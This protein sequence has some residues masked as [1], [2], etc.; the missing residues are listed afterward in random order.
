MSRSVER[1]CEW[2]YRGLWGVLTR[3]FKVPQHPPELPARADEHV[4]A[5]RPSLGFLRYLKLKFWIGLFVVD[6]AI[7]VGWVVVLLVSR[8][9]GLILAPVALVVAVVPDIIAYVAIHLRYDTTWYVMSQRSLR[10]RRGIWVIHETTITFENVQNVAVR[11]GPIQRLFGIANILV[12]TAG[13]GAEAQHGAH[14]ARHAVA[15]RGL[16]EGISEP[17]RL[18]DLILRRLRG[19]RSTGLGDEGPAEM[20]AHR[21][22]CREH[23]AVLTDIRDALGELVR[24]QAAAQ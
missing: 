11:Q 13:G 14:G 5:F 9:A 21:G 7:L 17:Q 6:L 2:I 15:H 18:R 12:D 10:I 19:T 20:A 1:A 16:I 24:R 4:D 23:V 3:W 8:T 22:W